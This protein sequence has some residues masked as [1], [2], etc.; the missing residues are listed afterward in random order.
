MPLAEYFEANP[1]SDDDSS[2]DDEFISHENVD[3]DLFV[4]YEDENEDDDD[5]EEG[6]EDD[7]EGLEDGAGASG[8]DIS[9]D[10]DHRND[11][12]LTTRELIRLGFN[13]QSEK[14]LDATT[15]RLFGTTEPRKSC[16]VRMGG[17]DDVYLFIC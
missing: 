4:I 10:D 11:C 12:S 6:E 14:R 17:P 9:D 3:E 1:S 5:E 2:D 13:V 16:R 8:G 7:K 15:F